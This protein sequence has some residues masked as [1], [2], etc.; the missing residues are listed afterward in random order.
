MAARD[1]KAHYVAII[2]LASA[3]CA[4][5]AGQVAMMG[6][7]KLW[8]TFRWAAAAFAGAFAVTAQIAKFL[9]W[10]GPDENS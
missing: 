10:F 9:G 7:E 6:G 5:L 1:C 2:L 4:L 8:A 3:V